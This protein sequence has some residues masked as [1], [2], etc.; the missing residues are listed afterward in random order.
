MFA[1]NKTWHH[2]LCSG[3]DFRA[4]SITIS[5]FYRYFCRGV[6]MFKTVENIENVL[7]VVDVTNIVPQN[8]LLSASK[9]VIIAAAII[10]IIIIIKKIFTNNE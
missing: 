2:V 6:G 9:N 7:L 10:I 8:G 4:C 5:F 1:P 3:S